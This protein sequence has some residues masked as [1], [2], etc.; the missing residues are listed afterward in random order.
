M[1]KKPLTKKN[2]INLFKNQKI[3]NSD[4]E[5]LDIKYSKERILSQD[6]ISK[7]NLPPFNNSAVD[8]YAILN[9][10]SKNKE[11]LFCKRKITAGDDKKIIVKKGEAIRIFTGA[12]MPLNSVTVLMQE[13]VK[14]ID[15]KIIIKKAPKIGENHRIKG[16]D[17]KKGQVILKKGMKIDTTNLNL[18]AAVGIKKIKVFKKI[19][20]GYFTSGNELRKPSINLKGSEINNSNYYSLRSL[21][22]QNSTSR[23]YCGNLKDNLKLIENKLINISKKFNLIITA[24]GASVGEEDHLVNVIN[25]LGK[26][27]F[28]KAAIKPG[29]PIA[30]GKIQNCYIICLPGN[31][32]SVQLLYAF[33]VK[34]FIE[35]L[36]GGIFLLPVPEKIKVNFNMSKKTKRMEWLRVKKRKINIEFFAEKFPKQGSG[37][38]SSMAYSDGIIEIP[39]N[40][41]KVKSGEKYDYYD[42]K[43]LFP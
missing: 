30:M 11:V 7:I 12:K 23:T 4:T 38:I 24:G 28:W 32:V 27:I 22:N 42:F 26:V 3:I 5:W 16:E 10:D 18:I 43:I 8:G 34:P 21:L 1:N 41:S 9:S 39:E 40:I 37:M 17:I 14:K 13:N 25:K 15:N 31:P 33:I 36:A 19:K 35:Y 20:V 29:R 2:I 6:V